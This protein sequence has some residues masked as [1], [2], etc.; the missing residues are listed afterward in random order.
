MNSL[1]FKS[2]IPNSRVI[3]NSNVKY[4]LQDK[5]IIVL[6]K[7]QKYK[8]SV[9]DEDLE[10]NKNIEN[11]DEI[12][13]LCLES[14]DFLIV[15]YYKTLFFV[16]LPI[17]SDI[18]CSK[19]ENKFRNHSIGKKITCCV[20]NNIENRESVIFADKIGD[21]YLL[22]INTF[23]K[24]SVK[25]N[26]KLDNLNKSNSDLDKIVADEDEKEKYLNK[27]CGV[28]LLYGHSDGISFIRK[29]N[30]FLITSDSIGK[31]KV[32][33]F[34]NVY[35]LESVIIYENYY[36]IDE[37]N[38]DQLLVINKDYTFN[39]WCLSSFKMTCTFS[40]FKKEEITDNIHSCIK[41][42]D[43]LALITKKPID[44]MNLFVFIIKKGEIDLK[45]K[46]HIED[47]DKKEFWINSSRKLMSI[48]ITSFNIKQ[49]Q[50]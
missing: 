40:Y 7:N 11:K 20:L 39:L 5:N 24:D 8:I 15:I 49:I 36:Y 16:P 2:L 35:E 9:Y 47:I 41:F 25:I 17:I 4:L 33:N 26:V 12:K 44:E 31:I 27:K 22:D 29:T 32:T 3:E 1:H 46:L 43:L 34:P 28:Y 30:K 38:N 10:K 48:D 21:I 13:I 14:K 50:I 37:V 6:D 45:E 19:K 42:D 23:V 18:L